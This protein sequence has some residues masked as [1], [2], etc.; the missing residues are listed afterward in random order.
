[1][2]KHKRLNK[3]EIQGIAFANIPFLGFLI[4]GLIPLGLSFYL[5]FNTFRGLRL[6]T[7]QFVGLDNFKEVLQ[8]ELFWQSISNTWFVLLAGVT[9]LIISLV[10][11]ALIATNVKGSKGFKVVYF[12]PYVCSMVAITF[13]WKWIYDYNYGVLNTTLMNWGWIK[14][15]IDWLGSEDFYRVAMFVLLVWSST[16]FN[17]ILLSA[18]LIG[19]PKEL[20]EAAEIDGAGELTRFFRITLPLISPTLFYL[21]VMG[22][23]G[24]MQEFARFQIMTPDGGPGYQG[25]TVV[26]YLYNKLF[27]A[28]G[29]S[30]LGV[31]TAVGWLLAVLIGVVTFLNFKMQNRWVKYDR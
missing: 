17:I 31:A 4:F 12:V 14:E 24:G 6:H 5:V 28:S 22:L 27:N 10:V 13:M 3:E 30:D 11:S 15:P 21:L 16:G 29:G 25:M 19:V 9:A 1:M 23:I 26:F 8:D 7:A 18:T 20:H 2:G